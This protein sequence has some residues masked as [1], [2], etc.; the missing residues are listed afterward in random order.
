MI[1]TI[2]AAL[3]VCREGVDFDAVDGEPARIF[4]VVLAPERSTPEHLRTL[5]RISRVLRNE[6]V[7]QSVLEA[8]G[9]GEALDVILSADQ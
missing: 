7:R 1:D 4:V 6:R 9:P 5:A 2:Q 3:A 8:P